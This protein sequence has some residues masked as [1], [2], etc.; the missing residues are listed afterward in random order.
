MMERELDD[1]VPGAGC[2]PASEVMIVWIYGLALAHLN[3]RSCNA[4]RF[5]PAEPTC[6]FQANLGL[7][8]AQGG[9]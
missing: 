4:R 5:G 9:I 2:V 6:G 8:M 3:D 7:Y 1:D